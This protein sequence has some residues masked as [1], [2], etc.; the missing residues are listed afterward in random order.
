MTS[1]L[2]SRMASLN[3][4]SMLDNCKLIL[5]FSFSIEAENCFPICLLCSFISDPISSISVSDI[6]IF[7]DPFGVPNFEFF[8]VSIK[9]LMNGSEIVYFISLFIYF[10]IM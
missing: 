9:I 10:L 3:S 4:I 7:L 2:R 1:I 8:V 6:I 5:Y